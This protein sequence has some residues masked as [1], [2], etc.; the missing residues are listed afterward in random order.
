MVAAI[1]DDR[2]D[3]TRPDLN[4]VTGYDPWGAEAG[5]FFPI[6][7]NDISAQARNLTAEAGLLIIE[8]TMIKIGGR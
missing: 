3:L 8:S 6:I 7:D 2:V 4:L 5:G 1:V